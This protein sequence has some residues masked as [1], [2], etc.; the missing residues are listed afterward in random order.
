MQ[1]QR[2]PD[3]EVV[4][5]EQ[6]IIDFDLL[7]LDANVG[8]PVLAAAIRT[9][10]DVKLQVL[11]EAGQSFFHIFHQPSRE[12]L[13]F[14][15]GQFAKFGAAASYCAAR[16]RGAVY[17]EPNRIKFFREFIR[18]DSWHIDDHQVLHPGGAEFTARVALG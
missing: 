14:G 11:I 9:A 4:S 12:A 18:I 3:A 7:A 8:D 15:D 10:G 5:I 2:S 16:E 17:L 1:T 13:G 6:T